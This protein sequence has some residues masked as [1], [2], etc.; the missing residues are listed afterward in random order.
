[1]I[2]LVDGA[3]AIPGPVALSNDATPEREIARNLD[4]AA[5]VG[6]CERGRERPTLAQY[7]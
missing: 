2:L 1:M 5:V 3:D 6:V 4:S 7:R